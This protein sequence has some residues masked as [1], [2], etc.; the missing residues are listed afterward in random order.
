M[1]GGLDGQGNVTALEYDARAADHNHLGYNEPDTVLIAQLAGMRKAEPNRGRATIPYDKY[2]IPNR[3]MLGSVVSLPLV[4]ETPVRTGNLRDPD[5]PQVTFALESF[6]DELAVAARGSA[7]AP[8][9]SSRRLDRG[10][11]GVPAGTVPCGDQGRRRG[12]WVGLPSVA[13]PEANGQRRYP[14]RPRHRLLVSQPHDG[15]PDRGSRSEPPDGP[16]LGEAARVRP[17]LRSRGQSR[18]A[19]AHGRVRDAA[20]AEPGAPRRGAVRHGEG[21]ERELVIISNLDPRGHA[22]ADRHR[23]GERGP[24]PGASRPPALRCG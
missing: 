15:G 17:R 12:L 21:H 11:R 14:H 6:I 9:S 2:T 4:W 8:A 10:G 19:Q 16:R 23:A 20:L 24:Q 7:R 13:E 3:R 18:G 5:G 1:R 22:G